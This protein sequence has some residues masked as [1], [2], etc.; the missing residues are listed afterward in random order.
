MRWSN[1]TK[2]DFTTF[3]FCSQETYRYHSNGVSIV[4]DNNLK[5]SL[6]QFVPRYSVSHKN[7][8]AAT[9]Y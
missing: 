8:N 5:Q 1:I 7:L 4:V 6:T 3:Y 2:E 9:K